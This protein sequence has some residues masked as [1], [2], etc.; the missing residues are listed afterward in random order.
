MAAKAFILIEVEVGRSNQVA[1][2]LRP[3]EGVRYA[4]V[5]T[6]IHDL[7]ACVEADTMSAVADL[8]TSQV[9]GIRGVMKTITCVAAG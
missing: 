2:A 9:Q 1:R 8:V 6:G 5:I 3:I 7:I 4:D